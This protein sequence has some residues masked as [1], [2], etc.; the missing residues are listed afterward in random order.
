MTGR[1]EDAMLPTDLPDDLPSFL[2]R[3]GSD[4]S[5]GRTCSRRAAGGV[6][7]HRLRP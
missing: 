1:L 6:P 7:L 2:E 3:F 5:A 4:S